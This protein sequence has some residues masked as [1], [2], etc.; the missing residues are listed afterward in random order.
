MSAI[1]TEPQL[2]ASP[3]DRAPVAG[4]ENCVRIPGPLQLILLHLLAL[5][6]ARSPHAAALG[7]ALSLSPRLREILATLAATTEQ[8]E[9]VLLPTRARGADEILIALAPRLPP[10]NPSRPAPMPPARPCQAR[11]P[12]RPR[13]CKNENGGTG[14]S[15]APPPHAHFITLS[16]LNQTRFTS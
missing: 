7:R 8:D 13:A 12:P 11:D 1:P 9:S 10:R 5:L 4:W 16:Y 6:F 3:L 2:Q 14:S 15:P